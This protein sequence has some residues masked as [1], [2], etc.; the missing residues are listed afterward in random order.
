MEVHY[1]LLLRFQLTNRKWFSVVCTLIDN[2]IHHHSGQN[3]VDSWGVADWVYNKFWPLWWRISLSIRVQTRLNHF[4][5]VFYHNIQHQRKFISECDQNHNSKKEQALSI[6]FPQYNWFISQ[7]ERSWLAITLCDK[8]MQAWRE[9]RCLDSYRQQQISHSDCK[10]T[11][12][13]KNIYFSLP[14]FIQLMF[15]CWAPWGCILF[16]DTLK[17]HLH[18]NDFR[19]HCRLIIKCSCVHHAEKSTHYP[20]PL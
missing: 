5:F 17:C 19:R 9:Q 16:K 3:V 1:S 7:N 10:I 15:H 12:N 14:K 8:L 2:N 13:C 20:S 18:Y 4:R 11:S 6:T